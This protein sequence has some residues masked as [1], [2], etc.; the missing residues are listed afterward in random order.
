[1]ISLPDVNLWAVL[2]SAVLTIVIGSFWYSPLLFGKIWMDANGIKE[3]EMKGAYK[4]YLGALI[5]SLL[6]AYVL[7][8]FINWIGADNALQGAFIG[9]LAWLGFVATTQFSAVLWEKKPLKLYGIHAG[10][11]LINLIVMGALLAWW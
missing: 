9:F 6:T 7:G 11:M 5:S 4:A 3:E 2:V 8:V 1:M 10:A